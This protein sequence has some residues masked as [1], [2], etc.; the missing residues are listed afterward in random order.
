MTDRKEAILTKSVLIP[1]RL[2]HHVSEFENAINYGLTPI[3]ID[4]PVEPRPR[5]GYGKPPHQALHDILD[6]NRDRYAKV[7]QDFLNLKNYLG[8]IPLNP[9][10]D[11]REPYWNNGWVEKL[12]SAALYCFTAIKS[13]DLYVEVGS[14]N[15]TKFVKRAILDHRLG[16][17]LYSID[18]RP[19]AEIDVLCDEIIRQPLET[20]DLSIFDALGPGDIVAI[21]SSHRCLTNS[22]VTVFFLEVLPHLK[23]GVLVYID[24]I[25]IP[26]DYPPGWS[27]RWY[28]EQYLLAV[29]LL[30]DSSNYEVILP[31]TFIARDPDLGVVLDELW[32]MSSISTAKGVGNGFW[33][34]VR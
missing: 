30:S 5:Y 12:D 29:L 3:Y 19:R 26:Y 9:T 23:S 31:A 13:P 21:D 28:S 32:K 1:E 22:D 4:Y 24:D 2:A 33:M 11:A 14:G 34:Q 15:S 17:K 27:G 10:D 8:A 7:L 20:L 16:T 25:Y 6:R 18:P